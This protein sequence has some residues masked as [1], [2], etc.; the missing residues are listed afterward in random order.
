MMNQISFEGKI[1]G[2]MECFCW[3]EVD[4][5]IRKAIVGED[6]HQ[7]DIEYLNDED[8]PKMLRKSGEMVL[9]RLY[10]DDIWEKLGL[11]R[12]KMYRFTIRAVDVEMLKKG[13]EN[14]GERQNFAPWETDDEEELDVS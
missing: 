10:P 11:D 3:D 4:E 13:M 2:D 5:E 14:E 1:S 9:Q 7:M 8:R 12:D 6:H